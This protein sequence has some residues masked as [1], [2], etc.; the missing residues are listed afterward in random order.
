MRKRLFGG[1]GRKQFF[2]VSTHGK[3]YSIK[4]GNVG[5]EKKAKQ[6]ER[7]CQSPQEAE[8]EA[9]RVLDQKLKDGYTPEEKVDAHDKPADKK[10]A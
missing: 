9:K 4:Q 5:E 1:A 7:T 2:E 6:E 8:A 3:G 10:K